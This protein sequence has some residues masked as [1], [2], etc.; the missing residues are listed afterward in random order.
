[1]LSISAVLSGEQIEGAS[2]LT[3]PAPVPESPPTP[4]PALP[5]SVVEAADTGVTESL[6]TIGEQ[7][8]TTGTLGPPTVADSE[9][10]QGQS[11]ATAT[12]ITPNTATALTPDATQVHPLIA[13][14]GDGSGVP[15]SA[16][17]RAA[18]G[19]V[20]AAAGADDGSLAEESGTIQEQ[21]PPRTRTPLP[22][23]G[24]HVHRSVPLAGARKRQRVEVDDSPEGS[25]PCVYEPFSFPSQS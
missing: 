21:L 13:I 4:S 17:S 10:T 7:S 19:Q 9:P 12:I 8:P 22:T 6:E 11:P 5:T 24:Q 18:L 15:T 14:V 16:G 23:V 25:A 1:M 20:L 2:T 3:S